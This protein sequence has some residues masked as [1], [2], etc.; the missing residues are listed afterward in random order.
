MNEASD[1]E[2]GQ[3]TSALKPE[4]ADVHAQSV[5]GVA[6]EISWYVVVAGREPGIYFG[7]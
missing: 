6:D 2:T 1:I 3:P 4:T 5:D 7:A